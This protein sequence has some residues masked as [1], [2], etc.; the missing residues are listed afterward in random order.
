MATL[1]V[2]ITDQITLN[3]GDRGSTNTCAV[4]NINQVSQEIKT[5]PI[6]V[7]NIG[8]FASS[9]NVNQKYSNFDFNNAK[10]IRVTNLDVNLGLECAFN[11]NGL[12]DQCS[13]SET[14]DMI[15]VK[16]GPLESVIVWGGKR[17]K[18]GDSR[19]VNYTTLVMT[20]LSYIS[21]NNPAEAATVNIEL[22]VASN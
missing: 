16:L 1:N 22:F 10:Y 3:G 17:S 15:A 4:T 19:V 5:L 8:T 12:D 7:T 2:T 20:D 9:V 21:L 18:Y 13:A 11:S 6:G 14:A